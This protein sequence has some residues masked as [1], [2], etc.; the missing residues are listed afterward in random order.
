MKFW[1]PLPIFLSPIR[2][3]EIDG[4]S[5]NFANDLGAAGDFISDIS[6]V[7][8]GFVRR[9]GF[10]IVAGEDLEL[11]GNQDW[12]NTIDPTGLILTI[13]LNALMGASGLS[14]GLTVVV[15]KTAQQRLFIRD[16]IINVL[17]VMG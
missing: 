16:A 14:Y 7:S 5:I 3:G 10:P 4:R 17:A 8:V 1:N 13:G 9:D 11:A 15:S 2:A 6:T 12:P